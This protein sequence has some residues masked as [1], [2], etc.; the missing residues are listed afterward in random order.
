M[1]QVV[2]CRA[3]N[4]VVTQS[5]RVVAR[6]IAF[7]WRICHGS[8]QERC[9]PFSSFVFKP[10]TTTFQRLKLGLSVEARGGSFL[11]FLLPEVAVSGG[12]TSSLQ[13]DQLTQQ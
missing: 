7:C 1:A 13:Q 2:A 11:D 10:F 8:E 3:H 9:R 5:M 6:K 12:T 4:P